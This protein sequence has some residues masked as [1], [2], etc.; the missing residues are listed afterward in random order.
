MTGFVYFIRPVG[1]EG[2]IKIGFSQSPVNRLSTLM[3]WSP[4]PLEIITAFEGCLSV[5]TA[6][7]NRFG[8]LHSHKEWFAVNH[9]LLDFIEKIKGGTDWRKATDF[10][11]YSPIKRNP[12]GRAAANQAQREVFSLQQRVWWARKKA[13]GDCFV[14]SSVGQ[15]LMDLARHAKRTNEV[16][17]QRKAIVDWFLESPIERAETREQRFGRAK[18]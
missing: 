17:E 12:V 5:E 9:E 3:A 8:H 10:K 18:V 13:G 15:A 6:I 14:P 2:P 7:H 1:A 11:I 16:D 4:F